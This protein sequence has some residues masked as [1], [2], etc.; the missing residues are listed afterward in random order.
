MG[1][2]RPFHRKR[3]PSPVSTGETQGAVLWILLSL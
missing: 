3:F 1:E 2:E